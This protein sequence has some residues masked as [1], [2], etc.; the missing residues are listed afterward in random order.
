MGTTESQSLTV[1]FCKL[2]ADIIKDH[3]DPLT[4]DDVVGSMLT[5][6]AA[7]GVKTL[8]IKRTLVQLAIQMVLISDD[9]DKLLIALREAL[10][11]RE[12][13]KVSPEIRN[14]LKDKNLN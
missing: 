3:D 6:T 5:T 7:L 8:G 13:M 9:E 4:H 11:A 14:A 10:T 1:K 2:A 12:L